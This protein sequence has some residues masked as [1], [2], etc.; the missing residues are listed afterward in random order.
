VCLSRGEMESLG[1]GV[2]GTVGPVVLEA[3]AAWSLM[4]AADAV[5]AA[6]CEALK[7]RTGV[8]R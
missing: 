1:A 8:P 4:Q 2:Y 7:V 5:A 3:A 6:T